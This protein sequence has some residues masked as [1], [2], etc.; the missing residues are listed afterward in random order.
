MFRGKISS[1]SATLAISA[2]M[3][4]TAPAV[5]AQEV[6][7]PPPVILPAPA[8]VAAPETVTP[9]VAVQTV[10]ETATPSP[11]PAVA[12]RP[13]VA[14]AATRSAPKPAGRISAPVA[15]PSADVD[16]N[17]AAVPGSLTNGVDSGPTV[18]TVEDT[19]VVAPLDQTPLDQAAPTRIADGTDDDW[20]IYGGLGAALAL[21]GLGGML[22]SRRRRRIEREPTIVSA[23]ATTATPKQR[24]IPAQEPVAPVARSTPFVAAPVMRQSVADKHLPPVDDPLF[25]H[26]PVLAPVTDPLFMHKAVLAPVTDPMFADKDE[27]VGRPSA[28]TA[29]DKRKDWPP[30]SGEIRKPLNEFEPAE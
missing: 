15:A 24:P 3:L 19:A 29:F 6:V 27:Y 2:A 25:A 28:S 21:A 13:A 5:F 17:I 18:A 23:T 11:E 10:T 8:P 14:R 9:P 1:N 12:A 30:A 7:A 22:V 4:C 26:R 16:D 20:M